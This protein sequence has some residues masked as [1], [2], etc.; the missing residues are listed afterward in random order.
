[1]TLK[2]LYMRH[3]NTIAIVLPSKFNSSR[4]VVQEWKC[5]QIVYSSWSARQAVDY[6]N[7]EGLNAVAVSLCEDTDI[8]RSLALPPD[9]AAAYFRSYFGFVGRGNIS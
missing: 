2:R 1:M 4:G 5:L 9:M 6:Y 8:H 3:P 7:R